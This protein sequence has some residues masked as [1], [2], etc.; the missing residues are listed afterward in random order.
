MEALNSPHQWNFS[1]PIAHQTYFQVQYYLWSADSSSNLT[2]W[3]SL[4]LAFSPLVFQ[5]VCNCLQ[6]WRHN[7]DVCKSNYQT[8][9][10]P[11][12]SCF[13]DFVG[14]VL[15]PLSSMMQTATFS[16]T[17]LGLSLVVHFLPL[18]LKDLSCGPLLF[19][20]K[21]SPWATSVSSNL[22]R[23]GVTTY[24]QTFHWDLGVRGSRLLHLW[25]RQPVSWW[26]WTGASVCRPV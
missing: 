2:C 21:V 17:S 11:C 3:F 20:K 4:K 8:V 1:L 12:A 7:F 14:F 9:L 16:Y 15:W 22:W 25:Y 18:K 26:L 23:H 19:S 10:T 13:Y 24:S 6:W 5:T